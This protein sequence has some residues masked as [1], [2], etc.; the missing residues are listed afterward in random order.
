MKKSSLLL[1]I[2]GFTT[3]DINLYGQTISAGGGHTMVACS[4]WS[5]QGQ[6][7]TW[8]NNLYGQ[9]GN[10]SS[11][12]I[13][14]LPVYAN[15]SNVERVAAGWSHCTAV[16]KDGTLWTWGYNSNGQLGLSSSAL[17]VPQPTQ[18][19][20]I[21]NVRS[22]A[23][24]HEHTL[25]LKQNGTVWTCGINGQGQLGNGGNNPSGTFLQVVGT[26]NVIQVAGG[27]THSMALKSDGTVWA[28]GGNS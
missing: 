26:T 1:F 19:M 17:S 11:V 20:N 21:N 24:G 2:F 3:S 22:V 25:V 15:I 4:Q 5:A 8:G 16:K 12:S 18:V 23:C 28:W 9:L 13:A 10:G 14:T 27:Y 7:M 6:A